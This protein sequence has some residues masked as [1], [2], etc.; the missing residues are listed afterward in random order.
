M[1]IKTN[2]DGL[3][4][5]DSYKLDGRSLHDEIVELRLQNEKLKKQLEYALAQ[6][7]DETSF[8]LLLDDKDIE[9]EELREELESTKRERDDLKRQLKINKNY[10]PLFEPVANPLQTALINYLTSV[11][12]LKS[13]LVEEIM[14]SIDRGDFAPKDA[15]IDTPQLIGYNTTISAPHMHALQLEL[16]RDCFKGA[17]RML[18]IGTGSGYMALAMAKMAKSPDVK[19]FGIDHIPKL[20][21]QAK[22]NVARNHAEF[23]EKGMV[24]FVLADGR[25]G[26]PKEGPFDII[27]VG[28]AMQE[29]PKHFLDQLAN[30]GSMVVP[31]GEHTQKLL[32]VHKTL[33]GKVLKTPVMSVGFGKLQSVEEQCP[34]IDE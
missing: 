3:L 13:P 12:V 33:A 2:M 34:D 8:E 19:V 23:L 26:L 5:G 27:I 9:I 16:L 24:R 20:V 15:Y 28:G 7:A 32:V 25:E 31:V 17:K 29:L 18:D 4:D 14:R 6:Q 11:E 10:T 30:G 22:E 21:D 1:E